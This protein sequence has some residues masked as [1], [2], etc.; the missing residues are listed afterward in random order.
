MNIL[1]AVI[2][3]ANTLAGTLAFGHVGQKPKRQWR[4]PFTRQFCGFHTGVM[5][6]QPIPSG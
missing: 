3:A 5:V 1:K 6:L 2:F 4:A